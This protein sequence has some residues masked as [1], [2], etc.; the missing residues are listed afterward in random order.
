[1]PRELT[2]HLAPAVPAWLI[3][4]VGAALLAL[5]V[6]GVIVLRRREVLPRGIRILT[7]LRFLVALVFL[8]CLMQP[9]VSYTREVE[10]IP[11]M[12]V[13]VDV[14]Q[15]M[16]LPAGADKA[17]RL[18]HAVHDLAR[19][20]LPAALQNNFRVHWFS[21]DRA[22]YP[23]AGNDLAALNATGSSTRY[24]QSLESALGQVAN[25]N[26]SRSGTSSCVLLVSDGRD[27][28]EKD[29]VDAAR[30]RNLTVYALAAGADSPSSASLNITDVQCAS[31][32]LLGSECR[33]LVTLRDDARKGASGKLQLVED[34]KDVASREIVLPPGKDELRVLLSHRPREAGLKKYELRAD[35]AGI[36]SGAP[37]AVTVQIVDHKHEVLVL[38]DTW[39]WEFK[40][41]RR[42][43]EDDPSFTFTAFLARGNTFVQFGE[44]DRRVKLAGFPQSRPE[45]DWFDVTILGDVD[46]RRWPRG[47]APAI[48]QWVEQGGRSLIVHAGPNLGRLARVPELSTLLPVEISA[49]SGTPVEGP[50]EVAVTP[51]GRQSPYFFAAGA[52]EQKDFASLPPL[53]QVYPAIRKRPAATVLVEAAK[54][55]NEFGPLIVMAEQPV[56]RG[57][58]LF[59]ASDTLWK[60]QTL[61]GQP[62]SKTTPH[63]RFWQQALRA[64]APTRVATGNI[65]LWLQPERS[66]YQAGQKAG[67]VAELIASQPVVQPKIQASVVLPDS[68]R[69]P[70]SF[71]PDAA[72]PNQWKCQFT[73]LQPGSHRVMAVLIS[74][75]KTAAE[76]SAVLDVDESQGELSDRSVD[77]SNLARIA[78]ATGGRMLDL[79][80]P[81]TW[82]QSSDHPPVRVERRQTL[83]LW[84]DF[85]LLVAL[86]V[87]LGADWLYRVLRG[88]I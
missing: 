72:Q 15:S 6:H 30:E 64:L 32:V 35:A 50:I 27:H 5:L 42:V 57:R 70:L 25:G 67:I 66:R 81:A 13:L 22:A 52:Q 80:D 47:L 20:D 74:E 19:S 78:T 82:P 88:Y 33:F 41:L 61:G 56:G 4:L 87:L 29:L 76:A 71:D 11:E 69:L 44:G 73:P 2:V 75:G 46:P 65:Q 53:D 85:I 62:E 83:D 17:D 58:V 36:A 16:S 7:A 60:W 51:E 48:G 9:V 18:Q 86:S 31:R 8:L 68:R 63:R 79:N 23:I 45:L 1:M 3:V 24:A 40:Y 26:H 55:G 21:F 12:L 28:G 43:F 14:S 54:R 59:I 49:D 34:G 39:R 37:Y 84:N 10:E 38:E 77:A